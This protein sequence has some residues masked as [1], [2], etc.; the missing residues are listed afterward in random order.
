MASTPDVRSPRY[1]YQSPN[2][3]TRVQ[4]KEEL[5]GL[6]DRLATYI[7]RMRYLEQQNTRLSAEIT[8]SKESVTREVGNV[9]AMFEAELGEARRLLDE[10]AKDKALLQLEN[11]KL[12][13]L[14]EDLRHKLE[15][16]VANRS[17]IE[18]ELKRV[19]RR[20]LEKESL[21][22][23]L[24]KERKDLEHQVKDLEDQLKEYQDDLE[25][26]KSDHE[27]EI[28]RRVDAE[29]RAQTLQEEVDFN[30]QVHA[31][32]IMDLRAQTE[33]LHFSL[34]MDDKVDNYDN[35]L[36]DKLQELRE[37]FEEEADNAKR[38]LEDAYQNKFETLR[39]E[40]DRD[41]SHVTRL[42]ES[43][44]NLKSELDKLRSD[45]SNLE[46]KVV[47]LQKRIS[48]LDSLRQHDKDDFHKQLQVRDDK[49]RL[50]QDKIDELQN[51]YEALLGIKIAL[52]VEIAAYRKLLE[53]EEERLNISTPPRG[54][55][56]KRGTK[57]SRA[58]DEEQPHVENN[59]IGS[60]EIAECDS[61]AKF[62]R[63]INNS[64]K[65]EPLGGWSVQRIVDGKDEQAVEYKFTP[66][67]V[68][69][70]KQ[71]VTIW[72]QNSGVKQKPPT[73]FVLKQEDWSH[74]SS[75]TTSL[76]NPDAEIVAKHTIA[77]PT[78]PVGTRRIR[79]VQRREGGE[80]ESCKIM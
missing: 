59:A 61:D 5:S 25:K 12:T 57:R 38:E 16:E 27:K 15:K 32:E 17:R 54:S 30:E 66:K 29:N 50:L 1:G 9:K 23:V 47:Q 33:S 40:S 13:S 26:E 71:T 24:S 79:K 31:K 19:E 60:I 51:E 52:D 42:I 37:E 58:D 75:M 74:G 68:L 56:S 4:E 76:I 41:R 36:R 49:N 43:N 3:R 20:L 39:A 64:D 35:I 11:N 62:V 72:S 46:S 77:L 48:D 28:I 55:T 2:V 21:N 14:V 45:Y 65:D 34:Q 63:L 70:G 22:I 53:G 8:T 80:R 44:T 67:F 78:P 10:T 69:K 6:N 7:D 18:E 73:D